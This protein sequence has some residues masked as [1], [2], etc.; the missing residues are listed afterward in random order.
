VENIQVIGCQPAYFMP[1]R[2]KNSHFE[3]HF[4][5]IVLKSAHFGAYEKN[6]HAFCQKQL[7]PRV[8]IFMVPQ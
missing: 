7:S 8:V 4:H 2:D 3:E 1:K 5:I 6:F